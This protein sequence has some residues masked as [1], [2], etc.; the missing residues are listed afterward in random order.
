VGDPVLVS[1]GLRDRSLADLV[2]KEGRTLITLEPD[3][4][5]MVETDKALDGLTVAAAKTGMWAKMLSG[6]SVVTVGPNK[7]PKLVPPSNVSATLAAA[8]ESAGGNELEVAKEDADTHG[9]EIRVSVVYA[10]GVVQLF[11][12]LHFVAGD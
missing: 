8:I 11:R 1:G 6:A 10:G 2:L 7:L 4:A 3:T 5:K 12:V 9:L